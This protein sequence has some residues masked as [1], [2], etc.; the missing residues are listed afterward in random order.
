MRSVFLGFTCQRPIDTKTLSYLGRN[1]KIVL[2]LKFLGSVAKAVDLNSVSTV[3]LF[4]EESRLNDRSKTPV[5]LV[6]G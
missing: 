3:S 2:G 1:D 4:T 6:D 5:A